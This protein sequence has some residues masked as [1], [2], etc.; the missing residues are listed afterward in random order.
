MAVRVMTALIV[1]YLEDPDAGLF[2]R[3]GF[4]KNLAR[5]A[6]GDNRHDKVR[7]LRAA[8]QWG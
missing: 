3:G 7:A 8:G 4:R 5:S 1:S 2:W 6:P